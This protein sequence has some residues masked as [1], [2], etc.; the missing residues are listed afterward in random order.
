M[1]NSR[2]LAR[3]G[4]GYPASINKTVLE[5]CSQEEYA[6]V[7]MSAVFA[8]FSSGLKEIATW[9]D[10]ETNKPIEVWKEEDIQKQLEGG[11]N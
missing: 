10:E 2:V 3:F 4:P 9:T 5:S 1:V 7:Q 11:R 8:Q 6:C